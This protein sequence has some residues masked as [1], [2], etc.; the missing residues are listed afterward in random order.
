MTCVMLL[1]ETNT[2]QTHIV[3]LSDVLHSVARRGVMFVTC[4]R[5]DD[6]RHTARQQVQERAKKSQA[7][8]MNVYHTNRD[9]I[10]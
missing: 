1:S 8:H 6:G 10:V 3:I 9:R 5:D 4:Q 2:E 7:E